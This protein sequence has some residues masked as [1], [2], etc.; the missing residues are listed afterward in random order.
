MAR[1]RTR[2]QKIRDIIQ[3]RLT[4]ELS[5]RQVARAL[6]VSRT[7]VAKTMTQF[8]SSGLDLERIAGM[9]DSALEQALWRKDRVVD[10]A[11]YQKLEKRF[12]LMVQELKK[13][14][15]TM[16]WLWKQYLQEQP[17]GYR[18]SQFCLHFERGSAD[19]K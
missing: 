6:K 11:R 1:K 9:S 12:P 14:G 16:E 4:T 10:T 13:K 3:K 8:R 15:M 19:R 18:Y 7:V 5:E 17:E 2:M